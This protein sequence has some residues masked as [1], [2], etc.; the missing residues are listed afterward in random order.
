M[1]KT[2]EIID[3]FSRRSASGGK[4]CGYNTPQAEVAPALWLQLCFARVFACE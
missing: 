3:G 4:C 2:I 1:L